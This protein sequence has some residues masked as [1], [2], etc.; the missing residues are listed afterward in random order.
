[1][2]L[3]KQNLLMLFIAFKLGLAHPASQRFTVENATPIFLA[4]SCCVR[5]ERCLIFLFLQENSFASPSHF[6]LISIALLYHI[7]VNHSIIHRLIII[8]W[9]TALLMIYIGRGGEVS[10]TKFYPLCM[11]CNTNSYII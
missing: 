10:E 11:C 4:K 7:I 1:M 5:N 6:L 3:S 9:R 8:S 2:L